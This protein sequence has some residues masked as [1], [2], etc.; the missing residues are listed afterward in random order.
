MARYS[1][2]LEADSRAKVIVEAGLENFHIDPSFGSHFFQ[3]VTSLRV[4]YFTVN[5]KG[6]GDS[7][8]WKWFQMQKVHKETTHL[9]W[10][11]FEEPLAIQMDGRIGAGAIIKP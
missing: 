7:L 4:G 8:D 5:P 3:N 2:K 1:G 10:L 9:K 6:K 11:K